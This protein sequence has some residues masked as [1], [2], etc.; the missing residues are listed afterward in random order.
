MDGN[1]GVLHVV[2]ACVCTYLQQ[3]SS[4]FLLVE[5]LYE[6]EGTLKGMMS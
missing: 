4:L 3:A 5:H 6:S 2:L 1:D